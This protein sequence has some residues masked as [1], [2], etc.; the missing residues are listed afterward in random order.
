[1]RLKLPSAIYSLDHVRFCA[2]ELI[3]YSSA[4]GQLQRSG[5]KTAAPQLSAESAEL[6]AQLSAADQQKPEA[7]LE[8]VSWLENLERKAATVSISLVGAPPHRLKLEIVDWLRANVQ[9][10][11][12]VDFHASPDIAG[13]VIIRTSSAL[14]DNSFRSLLAAKSGRLTEILDHV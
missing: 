6:L 12:M 9:P 10:L 1:M 13:G 7:I 2:E 8:A 4:L 5:A 3:A 11:T 14:Y